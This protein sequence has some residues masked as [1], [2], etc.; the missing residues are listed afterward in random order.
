MDKIKTSNVLIFGT[1]CSGKSFS[2]ATLFKLLTKPERAKQRVVILA[3]EHNSI[4]G[5]ERGLAHYK[6]ELKP[7]QL[8]IAEIRPKTKKAFSTKLN[9]LKL[10]AADSATSAYKTDPNSNASRD[11]YTYLVNVITKLTKLSGE[12]Y[13]TGETVELGNIAELEKEDILVIDGL[14]PIVHGIWSITQGDRILNNIA[15]YGVVQK[16]LMDI[17]S[18][19]VNSI[20]CSLIMLAHEEESKEGVLYPALNCGQAIFSRYLGNYSDVIYTYRT[21]AGKYVWAGKKA[22]VSTAPRGYP[23]EDNLVP[24]FSLYNF[25]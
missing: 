13:V 4:A 12:D 9:A 5:I 15:D 2:L 3:T 14:S 20:E 24:D 19:L 6:I 17:T 21:M 18:E 8:I 1:N 16:Q 11:K 7:N 10:F 22:K 23:M 25:F